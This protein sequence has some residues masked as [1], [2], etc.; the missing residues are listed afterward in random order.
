[1]FKLEE[2]T[3]SND[4]PRDHSFSDPPTPIFKRELLNSPRIRHD[5][6]LFHQYAD[7]LHIVP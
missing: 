1:M 5:G 2:P 6:S 4:D 7:H 3:F